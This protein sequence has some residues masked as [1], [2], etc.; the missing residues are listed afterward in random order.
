MEPGKVMQLYPPPAV[1]KDLHGLYLSHNLRQFATDIQPFVY[2]NFV[3]SL[4]GRIAV[5]HPSRPGLVVPESI[6]NDRDWRLFQE[7][8]VQADV[9]F[10]SGRYLRDVADGRAQEILRV[11]DD[12]RFK[13]LGA[14]RAARGLSPQPDL[15]VIS[16]GLDFPVPE[17]LT[18]GGRRVFVVTVES[19]DAGRKRALSRNA[20]VMIAGEH[21]VDGKRMVD[22][23]FAE[24]YRLFYNVTGPKVLHLLLEAG[25]LD[26]LYLTLAGR[27]LGGSPFSSI[28][29]GD[30]LISPADFRL[31]TLYF[32]SVGLDGVGQLFTSYTK[33]A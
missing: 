12:P 19:A 16:A 13:D 31:Q 6:A 8:A 5:P 14:W 10:T 30:L 17:V 15:A 32:D 21:R 9:L 27:L 33:S 29:E 26:R 20:Q 28:V 22:S 25:L 3:V 11:Y 1:E 23:L 24:G 18:Q 4:D 2:S 7:L